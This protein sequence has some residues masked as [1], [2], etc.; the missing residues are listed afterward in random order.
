MNNFPRGSPV[1]Q[2][3]QHHQEVVGKT[4]E[5][6]HDQIVATA[7]VLVS[8]LSTG[9]KVV[10]FGNGGSSTQASHF[11]GELLG[12]YKRDRQ[13]LP[14]IALA[15]D[16][17]VVTCISND[18]GYANVFERQVEALAQPGDVAVGL[19]TSGTSENVLRGLGAA[20]AHGARTITLTGASGLAREISEFALA[21]PSTST[22]HIQEIHLLII[23]IWCQIID[24]KVATPQKSGSLFTDRS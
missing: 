20:Q 3:F 4:L 17:A 9:H 7:E 13:P 1:S 6:L 14:A 22:A 11:A 2:H 8:A 21:V 10:V 24:E 12:R 18:F 23:H 15:C 19:T 16:P 5:T